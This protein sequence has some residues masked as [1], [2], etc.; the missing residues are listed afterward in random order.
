MHLEDQI[1]SAVLSNAKLSEAEVVSSTPLGGAGNGGAHYLV[2][3]PFIGDCAAEAG[4]CFGA[5]LS[6][7]RLRLAGQDRRARAV[8]SAVA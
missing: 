4:G 6:G 8:Q 7:I 1:R 2:R 5:A 3:I